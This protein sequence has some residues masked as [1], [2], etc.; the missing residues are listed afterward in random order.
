M[1]HR[2]PERLCKRE[3]ERKAAL[4]KKKQDED[5]TAKDNIQHFVLEFAK[6]K[7]GV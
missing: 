4:E 3:A 6:A 2:L 1:Q 5:A 7:S